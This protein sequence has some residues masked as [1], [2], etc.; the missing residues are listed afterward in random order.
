MLRKKVIC[1]LASFCIIFSLTG[2]FNR[3]PDKV[4]E[5][6]NLEDICLFTNVMVGDADMEEW[7]ENNVI[8]SVKWQ[9]LK[10]GESYDKK[11]PN[12][13]TA[14]DKY[15][16]E[17]LTDAKAL[18]YEF[19]SFV[20][21][22][23]GDEYNPAYCQAESKIY[24]QRADNHIVSFLEHVYE[25]TGGV[26]PN[27]FWLGQN[28][29]PYTG[30]KLKLT[31]VLTDCTDLPTILE[32]KITEKYSGV[33]F[34]DLEDTLSQYKP[35]DFTWTVDYQGITFWFSPYEIAAYAVGTLSAKI[36]FD[37]FPDMFNEEYKVAPE[38]YA[39]SLPVGLDIEFDLVED[40]GKKDSVYTE[41]VPDQ[42][43]SYNMLSTVVNGI[44]YTDEI[45][46]AYEFDVYL[47][48]M[49]NKNYIYS[50]SWSDNNYH[51][52]CAVDISETEMKQIAQ[53]SGTGFCGEYVEEG[54]ETGTLYHQVL[55]DPSEFRLSTRFDIL[56]TRDAF[57]HYK[58]NE[59]DGRPEMTDDAYNIEDGF[60]ITSVIPL[61][62][63]ILPDKST[64][65]IPA[66]TVFYPLRTD[67]KTYID[68]K[69]DDGTEVRFN[70]D[71]SEYPCK[72]NGVA[73]DECFENL[74]Y[75][76]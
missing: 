39:I 66:G 56:G 36:W 74:M 32:K 43:G 38:N 65:E 64:K 62:A 72:V 75:A 47:V 31:E 14:F 29:E 22:M 48:H 15:N 20:E 13:A 18:M 42:Y 45:N 33:T 2:C 8:T 7:H 35:E 17:S 10:L 70:Y 26:H 69:T 71:T 1:I 49:G 11:Y 46:Y 19:E 4:W 30:E 51:M 34:F 59:T 53:L 37:E 55:N 68:L 3:I 73:E 40:D 5:N 28:Y 25:Y 16:E 21:E 57:A 27:Y 50:D 24:M 9:K 12:L 76:G 52:I 54:Y 63:E 61:E 44:T 58:V 60:E 6:P 67:G 41:T 23:E